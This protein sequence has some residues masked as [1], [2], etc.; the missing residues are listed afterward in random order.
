MDSF[1]FGETRSIKDTTLEVIGVQK[2]TDIFAVPT[3]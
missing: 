2:M 3:G 1:I